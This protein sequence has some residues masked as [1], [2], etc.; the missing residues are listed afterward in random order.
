M[1]FTTINKTNYTQVARVYQE[2]IATGLATFE[3]NVPTWESWNLAHI[4]NCRIAVILKNEI[5]AWGALSPVSKREVY[6]GVAEVSVYVSEK[7]RGKGLGEVVLNNLIN[8]S[9]HVGI[10]TL[11]AGIMRDNLPSIKLH[12]KCGF[13]TIGFREKIGSLYGEWK[14]NIIMERRSKKVGV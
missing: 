9:E 7:S 6:K 12:E 11:Q 10:W 5:V 2:G 13:R 8:E 1:E 3:T 14:D 4:K